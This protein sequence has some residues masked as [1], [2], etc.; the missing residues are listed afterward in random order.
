M[1]IGGPYPFRAVAAYQPMR[2]ASRSETSAPAAGPVSVPAAPATRTA[3]SA[4]ISGLVAA[5]V[6]GGMDF[7]S[8]T[9]TPVR[10]SSAY[11]MYSRPTDRLE[12]AT[13]VERGRVIDLKA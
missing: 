3:S 7:N 4:S 9:M 6:P 5:R 13:G 11:Q 12:A 1:E 10:T 8:S 2:G